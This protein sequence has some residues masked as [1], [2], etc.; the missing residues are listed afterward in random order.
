MAETKPDSEFETAPVVAK[1]LSAP[2][3]LLPACDV[4]RRLDDEARLRGVPIWYAR[5]VF[6]ALR[7]RFGTEVRTAII[8]GKSPIVPPLPPDVEETVCKVASED[9]MIGELL[10]AI[11]PHYG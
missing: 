8:T 6:E 10:D 11:V 9:E 5:G 3:P 4:E 7:S 1:T 2:G